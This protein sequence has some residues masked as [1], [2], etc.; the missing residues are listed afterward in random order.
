MH[1]LDSVVQEAFVRLEV[2]LEK[3]QDGRGEKALAL[4]KLEEA[5]FWASKVAEVANP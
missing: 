3:L 4:I 1:E 2:E 5:H